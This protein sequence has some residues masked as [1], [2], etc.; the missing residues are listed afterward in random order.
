MP[1]LW[2]CLPLP[3]FGRPRR[4]TR[5]QLLRVESKHI[6][7]R[8]DR[9]TSECGIAVEFL[10]Q[11]AAAVQP[12]WT[13]ADVIDHI[14]QPETCNYGCRWVLGQHWRRRAARQGAVRAH[15]ARHSAREQ[16]ARLRLISA[17]A[18]AAACARTCRP[19][20]AFARVRAWHALAGEPA[21]RART[22]IRGRH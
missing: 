5:S 10:L 11:F 21:P 8:A 2:G 1:S 17:T 7:L 22:Q 9:A 15:S 16:A 19:P 20:L 6:D 4:P 3:A 14:V 18:A 12:S 13:S